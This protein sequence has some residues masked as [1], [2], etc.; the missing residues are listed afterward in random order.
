[1][2]LRDLEKRAKRFIGRTIGVHLETLQRSS[3]DGRKEWNCFLIISGHYCLV[4]MHHTPHVLVGVKCRTRVSSL[5][6]EPQRVGITRKTQRQK[7]V[8]K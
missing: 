7:Y 4:E 6:V 3:K 8:G 5:M 2:V 1:M